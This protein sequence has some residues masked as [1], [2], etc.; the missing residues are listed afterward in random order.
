ML[1]SCRRR[2]TVWARSRSRRV[3][4]DGELLDGE[5]AHLVHRARADL[6]DPRADAPVR[7]TRPAGLRRPRGSVGGLT[8]ALA[9]AFERVLLSD[10]ERW[11]TLGSPSDYGGSTWTCGSVRVTSGGPPRRRR[12]STQLGPCSHA[13]GLTVQSGRSARSIDRMYRCP[14]AAQLPTGTASRMTNSWAP[15]RAEPFP[16]DTSDVGATCTASV[17]PDR[18][19]T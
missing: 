2:P 13:E 3:R 10:R 12:L 16:S 11:E 19:I 6:N 7:S 15:G 17:P 4:G 8:R 14:R 5:G 1:R 9:G 18:S